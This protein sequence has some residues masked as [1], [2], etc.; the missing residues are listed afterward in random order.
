[1]KKRLAIFSILVIV[2]GG[3]SSEVETIDSI[4]EKLATRFELVKKVPTDD[5]IGKMVIISLKLF[6][7][8]GM[9]KK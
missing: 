1:M 5:L 6:L 3:C 4:G 8:Q 2:L 9:I 7:I